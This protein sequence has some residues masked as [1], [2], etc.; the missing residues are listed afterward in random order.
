MSHPPC[1]VDHGKSFARCCVKCTGNPVVSVRHISRRPVSVFVNFGGTLRSA[2]EVHLM[3]L[4]NLH[5][6]YAEVRSTDEILRDFE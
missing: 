2:Q 3:S 5:G 4:S 1:R 6:E